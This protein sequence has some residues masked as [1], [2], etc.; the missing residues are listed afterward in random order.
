MEKTKKIL[1]GIMALAMSVGFAGCG[2]T[3]GSTDD[4]GNAGGDAGTTAETTTT[5]ET[6]PVTLASEEVE[7]LSGS[8]GKLRDVELENKTVK[9]LS[10]WDINPAEGTQ[11]PVALGMFK[12]KY[13]GEIKYYPV[14]WADRYNQLSTYV[15]GG[16]GIDFFPRDE[17]SLPNGVVSGM[18]QPVDE[19]IDINDELWSTVSAGMD[20]YNFNGKHYSL[21]TGISANNVVLY[22]KQTIEDNGFDDP[23]ELYEKGEWNWD[24]F[25][26]MLQEFV[27]SDEEHY[28]LDG[29]WSELAL[30]RSGG[31]AFIEAKDGK[32]NVNLNSPE[33]ERAQNFMLDLYN[34][35]CVMDLSLFEWVEQAQFMGEGKE[36]FHITGSWAVMKTPD[37]WSTKI[38]PEN[39]GMAP[40]PCA[41]D[42]DAMY[43]D[44]VLDG[45]CITK[46]AANPMGAVLYAECC[47]AGADDPDARKVDDDRR[48][49]DYQWPE[50]V[51]EHLHEIND[52]ARANPVVDIAG[53][54]SSDIESLTTSNQNKSV[55][56]NAA[57]HGVPWSQTR[58]E[59]SGAID[60]LVQEVV[61]KLE[62]AQA[63]G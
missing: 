26:S 35:G 62:K 58:D 20:K 59:L 22:N 18:F 27:D 49:T 21:V 8:M 3:G 44:A 55:G 12:E 13:G 48:R 11:V 40:V 37:T 28:G 41:P 51:I 47:L 5:A 4:S 34:S 19:Y 61:D 36:L 33:I 57:L 38:P 7:Q 30:Y 39:L 46:G 15:L 56:L 29:W 25:K 54:M 31:V 45:F 43:M 24:T 2:E 42:A 10:N 17:S 16:E 1:A 60:V 23:W 32:I 9:W 14:E 63:E 53:G 6:S 52:L 50:D